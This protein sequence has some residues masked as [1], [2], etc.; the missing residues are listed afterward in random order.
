[1]KAYYRTSGKLLARL[2]ELWV[3]GHVI[4]AD[5]RGLFLLEE[6][7][8]ARLGENGIRL[9]C[10]EQVPDETEGTQPAPIAGG[11]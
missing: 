11:A 2:T 7:Q 4:T 3:D 1:V 10:F 8:A 6:A 5:P 9:D